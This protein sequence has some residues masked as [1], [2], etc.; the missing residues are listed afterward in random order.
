MVWNPEVIVFAPDIIYDTVASLDGW[1]GLQAIETGA[2]YKTPYGPYGWL[3]SPPAVQRY[4]GMLWLGELL[5]PAYTDY[6][7][8][9]EI[10]EYY[11]MFYGC[12]LTDEM[13]QNLIANALP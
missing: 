12:E 6:D 5:Y 7:F 11:Q 4:L 1:Q 10:T 9:T 13:Y 8:Q 3:S 2:Y